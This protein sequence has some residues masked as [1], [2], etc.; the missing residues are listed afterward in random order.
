ML[1]LILGQDGRK[2]FVARPRGDFLPKRWL[3]KKEFISGLR[4]SKFNSS[5]IRH[6]TGQTGDCRGIK[7][8]PKITL[9]RN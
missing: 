5:T 1:I 9:R 6:Y 8:G 4:A 2:S 7:S 3:E